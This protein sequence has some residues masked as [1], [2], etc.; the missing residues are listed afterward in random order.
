[1]MSYPRI[2]YIESF[3]RVKGASLSGKIV[4]PLV[5]RFVV[6]WTDLKAIYARADY[7]G[8]LV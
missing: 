1:M 2:V 8:K 6:Q 3:A 7:L 5:D 4:Y